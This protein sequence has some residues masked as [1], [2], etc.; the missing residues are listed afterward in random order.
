MQVHRA[1]VQIQDQSIVKIIPVQKF[2]LLSG[3]ESLNS[4]G[5]DNLKHIL[6]SSK[7][8]FWKWVFLYR[9]TVFVFNH[10]SLRMWRKWQ[11]DIFVSYKK[12]RVKWAALKLL[13]FWGCWWKVSF[14]T[15]VRFQWQCCLFGL[16]QTNKT[17]FLGFNF[18]ATFNFCEH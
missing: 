18:N 4:Y 13:D 14:L 3:R 1:S 17:I 8:P 5:E 2:F 7:I 10:F 6:K 12:N 9:S 11:T 16:K 15:L